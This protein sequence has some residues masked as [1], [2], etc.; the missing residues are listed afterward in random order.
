M[1]PAPHT[2]PHATP[3][4]RP[5]VARSAAST[6]TA[7]DRRR[8]SRKRPHDDAPVAGSPAAKTSSASDVAFH[9]AGI[10][11]AAPAIAVRRVSLAISTPAA[12][13][14]E[15]GTRASRTR[16]QPEVA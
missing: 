1:G 2:E 4:S 6:G 16:G 7:N 12:Q 13:L 14:L 5:L 15:F 9:A 10:G 3:H 8:H 11:T